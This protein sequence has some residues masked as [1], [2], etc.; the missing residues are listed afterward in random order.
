MLRHF[1]VEVTSEAS[2]HGVVISLTGPVELTAR[3]VMVPGDIS[4]AAFPIVAALVTEGSEV[5]VENVGMN[6]LRTGIITSLL[7]MGADITP[8][9]EREE[10][11]EPVA[12]LRVRASRLKGAEIP[13]ERAPSMIDEYPILA[14]AAAHAEGA[15]RMLGLSE[16]RVKESDRLMATAKLLREAGVQVDEG[17]DWMV[18]TGGAVAGGGM[19]ETFMDHRIAMSGV[20]LGL[21]SGKGMTIDD[22]SMIDTSFPGFVDLMTS[23]GAEIRVSSNRAAG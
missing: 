16:L 10:A 7:E 9:N 11:G 14:V 3:D 4:S 12:D 19:V 5:I 13:A 20:V 15:T 8:L 17:E 22:D 1:G 21:G 6:V 18:V 23:M 2:A